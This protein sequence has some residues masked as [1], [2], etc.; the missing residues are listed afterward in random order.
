MSELVLL[1]YVQNVVG[2]NL[3]IFNGGRVF[4]LVVVGLFIVVIGTGWCFLFNAVLFLVV[5]VGLVMMW[6]V[7]LYSRL[8]VVWVKG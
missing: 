1:L 4:G 2:F 7:E 8:M 5:I 3:V 6:L